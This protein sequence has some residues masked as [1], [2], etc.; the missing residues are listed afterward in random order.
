[1]TMRLDISIG[2][3]QGFVT[4]SRRT[5]DLWG[6]SYLLSFLSAH[7]MRGAQ[8]AGGRFIQPVAEVVET[9]RLYRWVRGQ[10]EDESPRIGSV[11]NHFALEVDGNVQEVAD[12]S[13]RALDEAWMRVCR[14]VWERFVRHACSHGNATDG[15]WHRQIGGFWEVMWTAGASNTGGGL[16]GR[17]KHWRSH[18]PPEEPGDKCTVMHDWQ[19]L[20][21]H[22]RGE[23]RTSR[24]LQD[25]FWKT[26]R[27]G[28]G[29]LGLRDN[30]RL[31]AVALVKRL[32]PEVA[33]EALGWRVD[34]SHW[35]STVY[36][37]AL[38]WICRVVQTEPE[39]ASEYAAAVKQSTTTGVLAERKPLFAGLEK[40]NA[41]DFA[42]LDANYMRRES[43]ANERLCP[44]NDDAVA[45]TR[46][47]L[48][49]LLQAIYDAR[50][51]SRR[52][53]GPPP[54]F[55]ALLLA[56]GDRLGKLLGD[57]GGET[58][59]RALAA[60][61]TKVPQIVSDSQGVTIY[62]GGDDVLAMLPVPDA[63]DCADKLADTYRAAFEDAGAPAGTTLSA[64]VI[65]AHIRL[66]LN[67]VVGEA[68]RLLDDVAKDGNG[69]NS[70]VAAVLKPGGMQC[71]WT[72]TWV[73]SGP[74]GAVPA[75]GSLG[76]LIGQLKSSTTEPGL[77]S[78]LIYRMRDT[79]TRLCGWDSW[80]PGNWGALPQGLDVRAFLRAEIHHSL[81]SRM[82]GGADARADVM[83]DCVW[84][85]LGPARNPQGDN[86]DALLAGNANMSVAEAGVDSLLLA[87]FLA[88]PEEQE[89]NR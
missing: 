66:P 30:E 42:R 28:T 3:V 18:H 52:K 70:L 35:P 4:Q 75:V 58:V 82:D 54:A 6:S 78:S 31:C 86:P 16:L 5:R 53:L 46:D 7:A 79:L 89:S 87:R 62:A 64:A 63:L 19:E 40:E 1:M 15:I 55:Y 21:G 76:N 11:S 37:G 67:H 41:G 9:D 83:A 27:E 73:R 43:V 23:S 85:L 81:D 38:P 44:L 34:A 74:E 47:K 88:D 17:R 13:I 20:S 33:R 32:F 71:Q 72:T 22:V 56:D 84:N 12:E 8:V 2:P 65:F 24:D 60:F 59:S 69:R 26:V 45:G 48:D 10:R 36:V 25:R 51:E 57:L 39:L 49:S 50:D 77:S 14:A 80:Q 29:R 61:T 68:H